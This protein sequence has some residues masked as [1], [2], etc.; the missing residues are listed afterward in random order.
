MSNSAQLRLALASTFH[1]RK[2]Q[3]LPPVIDGDRKVSL[4]LVGGEKYFLF[5][6]DRE[7]LGF[8]RRPGMT[9]SEA[10]EKQWGD[11]FDSPFFEM[12]EHQEGGLQ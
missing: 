9:L 11:V 1:G 7:F 5:E 3:P 12:R 2:V 8:E 10:M 4:W 6:K